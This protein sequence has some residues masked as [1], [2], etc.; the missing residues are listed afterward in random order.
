MK[1][2]PYTTKRLTTI[3]QRAIEIA[4]KCWQ[5]RPKEAGQMVRARCP[6]CDSRMV[7]ADWTPVLARLELCCIACAWTWHL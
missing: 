1:R 6:H 3:E 4:A 2:G 5:A 7:E